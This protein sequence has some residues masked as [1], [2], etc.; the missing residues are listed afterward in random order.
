[1]IFSGVSERHPRLSVAILEFELASVPRL[2]STLSPLF[3]PDVALTAGGGLPLA[4]AHAERA[5]YIV[6]GA[7]RVDHESAECSRMLIFAI[8]A[9]VVGLG[10]H[11]G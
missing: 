4:T 8:G 7:V 2:L 1:M 3:Y 10:D 5:A 9:D 6:D 11:V